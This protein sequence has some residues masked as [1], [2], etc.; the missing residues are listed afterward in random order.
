MV[1]STHRIWFGLP[2]RTVKEC[3]RVSI[4]P[5]SLTQ[6]VS[7]P[8]QMQPHVDAGSVPHYPTKCDSAA[9]PPYVN[10]VW[11]NYPISLGVAPVDTGSW[12]DTANRWVT[13]NPGQYVNIDLTPYSMNDGTE[14]ARKSNENQIYIL[15][16]VFRKT[17]YVLNFSVFSQISVFS[18]GEGAKLHFSDFA[19]KRSEDTDN[20]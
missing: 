17:K 19:L 5:K 16:A 2:D 9:D 1:A 11:K 14:V 6:A 13:A 7:A 10:G 20:I 8:L 18:R 3:Y 4:S 15:L 12:S